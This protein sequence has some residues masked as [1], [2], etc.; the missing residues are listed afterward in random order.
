MLKCPSCGSLCV[1]GSEKCAE[2]GHEVK[3]PFWTFKNSHS[4]YP[5]HRSKKPSKVLWII[6]TG[7]GGCFFP[8]VWIATITLV[9]LWLIEKFK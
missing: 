1:E 8:P 7:I 6:I 3:A 9:V 5:P 4:S 2:C